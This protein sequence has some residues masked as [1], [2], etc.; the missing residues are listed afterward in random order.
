M[1]TVKVILT[2]AFTFH[3]AVEEWSNGYHLA[4]D[5][6][7]D[8]TGY[9]ALIEAL[10]T[11]VESPILGNANGLVSALAYNNP[12]GNSDQSFTYATPGTVGS[13]LASG[14]ALATPLTVMHPEACWLVKGNAGR[15]SKGKPRYLTKYYHPGVG[16]AGDSATSRAGA[17]NPVVTKLIDGSLPG[18][19]KWCAPDGTIATGVGLDAFIRIHQLKRRGKRP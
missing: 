17:I 1:P 16:N 7:P 11:S 3:G 14:S 19:A 4:V 13:K 12:A 5:T 18:A 8:R 2:K 10:W 15:T 6:V 9:A